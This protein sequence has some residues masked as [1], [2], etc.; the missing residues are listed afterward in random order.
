MEAVG[1]LQDDRWQKVVEEQLG[2][3]P[4][5]HHNDHDHCVDDVD[6]E[7]DDTNTLGRRGVSHQR[8]LHSGCT[9]H[10]PVKQ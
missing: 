1:R 9:R 3:E 7:K 2:S 6:G 10:F 4:G 8:S 5:Y